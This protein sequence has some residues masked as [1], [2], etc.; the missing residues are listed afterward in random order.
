MRL[1]SLLVGCIF[2]YPYAALSHMQK[3]CLVSPSKSDSLSLLSSPVT[4]GPSRDLYLRNRTRES[5]RS[6][7]RSRFWAYLFQ[8]T[9]SFSV[10]SSVSLSLRLY[11]LRF[12]GLSRLM[13]FSPAVLRWS[14]CTSVLIVLVKVC[15]WMAL[16]SER[17]R[18]KIGRER[19]LSAVLQPDVTSATRGK[20]NESRG[21]RGR[22]SKISIGSYKTEVASK[23][24]IHI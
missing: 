21:E 17:K 23:Q 12:G 10:L 2:R 3:R 5:R 1:W 15:L 19:E 20:F 8:S 24:S 4:R 16:S 14:Q 9:L 7:S 18:A 22:E 13:F 11:H 6:V